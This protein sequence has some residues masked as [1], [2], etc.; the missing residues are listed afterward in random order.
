VE[1]WKLRKERAKDGGQRFSEKKPVRG[2]LEGPILKP[3]LA[4][5]TD[6]SSDEDGNNADGSDMEDK[7]D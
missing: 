3:V 7:A 2:K 4:I 5:P 1:E 6:E